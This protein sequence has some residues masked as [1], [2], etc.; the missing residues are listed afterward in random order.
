MSTRS[1]F[2]RTWREELFSE[3]IVQVRRIAQVTHAPFTW[4][5]PLNLEGGLGIGKIKQLKEA[6]L[7]F[8]GA[9]LKQQE[10][11]PEAKRDFFYL[12]YA[13]KLSVILCQLADGD[14]L[15]VREA[16]GKL[17]AHVGG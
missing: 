3:M 8:E 12:D 5:Y 1:E 17:T 6:L 15:F 9:L 14:P 16:R 4:Y 13:R 11:K 7:L 2:L 10:K